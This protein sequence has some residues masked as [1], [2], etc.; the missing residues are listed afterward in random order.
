LR[1]IVFL[2]GVLMT[3]GHFADRA[4]AQNEIPV[5]ASP[6]SLS[7][8]SE[9]TEETPPAPAPA[10]APV[11]P[12]EPKYT[13]SKELTDKV[14]ELAN[15]R[16]FSKAIG[17][18]NEALAKDEG[19]A[20]LYRLRATMQC[21]AANMK[22]C[23]EDATKAV[24]LDRAYAPA[25]IF[26]AAA[27]VDA[28]QAKDALSDC[29]VA[30]RLWTER[31]IGYNCKGVADRALR[32]YPEAI[33]DFDEA[34]NRDRT[35]VIAHFNKGMT[36]VLQNKPE[37]AIASFSAAIEV[38]KDY[39]DAY[40]QRGKVRIGKGDVTGARDDF[41]KALSLNGRNFTAAVGLEALQVGKALDALSDKK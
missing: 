25:F 9:Q 14:Q 11:A 21:R 28:G 10:P 26:R 29:E 33:A 4:A 3:A 35:F 27:R 13:I 1:A 24:E 22:L 17:L 6:P 39:D 18:I 8:N 7:D 19:N 31:P 36:F 23:L 37:D 40:A 38:K 2:T 32:N 5:A 41:A 20:E 34:L 16:E 30:I 15:R 12:T